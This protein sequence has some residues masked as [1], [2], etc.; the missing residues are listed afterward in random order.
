DFD[1]LMYDAMDGAADKAVQRIEKILTRLVEK[2]KIE[3]SAKR[4]AIGRI[5]PCGRLGDFASADIAIE[6][7]TEKPDIKEQIFKELDA[8]LP[9]GKILASNTSSISIN[10]LAAA[11][12][13]PEKFI[14]MHFFNPVPLMGLVEI[15]T[16]DKTDAAT[17]NAVTELAKAVGKQP[18]Q[19]KDSPGFIS[20][21]VGM[22]MINEAAFCLHD[23]IATREAI[24]GIMKLGFNHPMGPLALA[25][26]IGI[27][28][29]L[30]IMEVLHRDLANDKYRP[31]PLLKEM[32][33]KGHLGKKTGKGF[34]D[35]S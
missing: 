20:N 22:P 28:V 9:P 23:G 16:G 6:A 33:A 12:S 35:Y 7:A 17:V 26:L 24:D 27:D 2:G 1:V 25:D 3:E 11:T 29:C 15:V 4:Q 14:G 10:R 30:F 5:K 13:R 31:C 19:C 34:Y 21:R 32:V 18:L 8:I